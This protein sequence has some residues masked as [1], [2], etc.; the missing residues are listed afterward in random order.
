[1]PGLTP[2]S[3]WAVASLISTTRFSVS[4]STAP[5]WRWCNRSGLPEAMMRPRSSIT[6]TENERIFIARLTICRARVSF[7]CMGSPGKS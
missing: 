1:M 3:C 7:S 6:L 2:L 4:A 5:S